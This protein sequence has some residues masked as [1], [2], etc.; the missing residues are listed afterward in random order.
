M[1][2]IEVGLRE[3]HIRREKEKTKSASPYGDAVGAR[4]AHPCKGPFVWKE[5][6][7]NTNTNAN[8]D[9]N[10]GQFLSSRL[11][12]NRAKFGFNITLRLNIVNNLT[13]YYTQLCQNFKLKV[14]V[15]LGIV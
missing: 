13:K 11:Y 5:R 1:S 3:C 15:V 8:T 10:V 7:N 2:F 6:Q 14:V 9:T 12:A 4:D